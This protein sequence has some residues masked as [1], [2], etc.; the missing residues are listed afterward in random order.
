[1]DAVRTGPGSDGWAG[2]P[3]VEAMFT[4]A[5]NVH[6]RDPFVRRLTDEGQVEAAAHLVLAAIQHYE[7]SAML[8]ALAALLFWMTGQGAQAINCAERAQK[9]GDPHASLADL[10]DQ[11]VR[12]GLP[13]STWAQVSLD[14][15]MG[16]LRGGLQDVAEQNA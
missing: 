2:F 15:P 12:V 16:V 7:P 5:Q 6:A 11:A 8:Y 13:P 3:Q 1:M 10:V 14:I 4:V 9:L